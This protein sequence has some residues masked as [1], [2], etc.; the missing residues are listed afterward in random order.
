MNIEYRRSFGLR[1]L[2]ARDRG[3]GREEYGARQ[4]PADARGHWNLLFADTLTSIR[5]RYITNRRL[6]WALR[7]CFGV[8]GKSLDPELD[9]GRLTQ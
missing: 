8:G 4:K 9:T 3:A 5:Q 2:R 6:P 1:V 7:L